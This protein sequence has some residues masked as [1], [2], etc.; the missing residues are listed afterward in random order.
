MRE[1]KKVVAQNFRSKRQSRFNRRKKEKFNGKGGGVLIGERRHFFTLHKK[2]KN[3]NS[4]EW[5]SV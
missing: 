5:L 2:R 4:G 1:I 3:E